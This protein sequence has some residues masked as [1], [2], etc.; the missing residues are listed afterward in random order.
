MSSLF[1]KEK[2]MSFSSWLH[3]LKT[4]WT[5]AFTP[6]ILRKPCRRRVALRLLLEQFEGRILPSTV[7]WIGGSGSWDDASHWFD[8]TTQTNHVPLAGDDVVLNTTGLTGASDAVHSLT[9]TGGTLS[10]SGSITSQQLTISGQNVGDKHLEGLTLV[11][12]GTGSLQGTTLYLGQ[13]AVL[14]NQ[15]SLA[16]A[17]SALFED[18]STAANP[19]IFSNAVGA[20]FDVSSGVDTNLM[21]PIQNSGAIKVEQGELE[22]SNDSPGFSSGAVTG[23]PGTTLRFYRS[24]TPT[25]SISGDNVIFDQASGNNIFF[26]NSTSPFVAD[27]STSSSTT[28]I[29][30]ASPIFTGTNVSVGALRVSNALV[31]FTPQSPAT[32][33]ASS[34]QLEGG[35]LMGDEL[36]AGGYALIKDSGAYAQDSAS[37]LS[38][39]IGGSAA[40]L[41]FDRLCVAG[42]VQLAGVLNLQLGGPVGFVP[43]IG[44]AFTLIDNQGNGPITGTFTGLAEGAIL[45]VPQPNTGASVLFRLTYQGGDG[46]DVVLTRVAATTHLVFTAPPTAKAAGSVIPAIKVSLEDAFGNVVVTD[47]SDVTL[48]IG[49][50]SGTSVTIDANHSYATAIGI[51]TLS[52]TLTVRAVNGV[53][54]FSDLTI[55]TPGDAADVAGY[56]L[57]ASDGNAAAVSSSFDVTS[58]NQPPAPPAAGALDPLFGDHGSVGVFND[59]LLSDDPAAALQTDGKIVVAEPNYNIV[60]PDG[61]PLFGPRESSSGFTVLRYQADGSLDTS[62]GGY[63]WGESR[64]G[65]FQMFADPGNG[66]VNIIEGGGA[67]GPLSVAVQPNDDKILISGIG[68]NYLLATDSVVERLN[69]DGSL[70]TSFGTNGEQ[71]ISFAAPDI[72]VLSDGRIVLGGSNNDGD[73]IVARLCANGSLDSTFG[74]GGQVVIP[75]VNLAGYFPG[76]SLALQSDGKIVLLLGNGAVTRL[77]SDGSVDTSFGSSSKTTTE[78]FSDGTTHTVSGGTTPSFIHNPA[79]EGF[80]A[81]AVYPNTGAKPLTDGKIVLGG[82]EAVRL[83]SDGSL[84]TSYGSGG[85]VS[86]GD[87]FFVMHNLALQADGK[88]LVAGDGGPERCFAVA[89]INSGGSLDTTFGVGAT[90]SI[91]SVSLLDGIMVEP[92]GKVVAIGNGTDNPAMVGLLGG[93]S[94]VT[95]QTA[96]TSQLNQLINM[97]S[98]S[99]NPPEVTFQANG[100][101]DIDTMIAAVNALP[102]ATTSVTVILD[103]NGGTYS[104]NGVAVDP[105]ANVDFTIQNG[106]LDPS[107]PA[108]TVAGGN[109]TVLNCT[110]LTTGNVPTI[111]VSGGSL[112]LRNDSIIQRATAFTGPAIAVT[113]GNLDLGTST[114]PGANVFSVSSGGQ[115]VLNSTPNPINATGNSF[116]VAGTPLPAANLTFTSLAS[117]VTSSTYGQ[118]VIIT[119]TVSTGASGPPTGGTVD[120]V[121]ASS[122]TDLGT[123]PLV[124]GTATTSISTLAAGSH[125]ITARYSGSSTSTFSS[126]SVTLAVNKATPTMSWA[127]PANITYGTALGNAQLNAASSAAVNGNTVSV[128]G[129]FVYGPATGAVLQ[130]GNNQPLTATFTP[131]DTADY[132]S[133]SGSTTIN[134]L[135]APLTVTANNQTRVYGTPNPTFAVSYAGFVTGDTPASLGGTLVFSTPATINSPVGSYVITPSG[136]SSANYAIS[137]V[138]ATLNVTL[139]ANSVYLLNASASGALSMS[140]NAAIHLPGT[141]IVDSTSASAISASGNAQVTATGGV[142][143]AGGVQKSGNASVTKTGTP[144]ATGDPL[145]NLAGPTPPSYT[146][147]PISE[148]IGANT[149]ATINPGLYSQ[150]SVSGNAKLTLNPGVYVIGLGGV[151]VSLNASLTGNGVTYILEGGGFNVSGNASVSGS[152]VL[153][154]NGGSNYPNFGA[155]GQTYGAI[156]LSSNGSFNLSAAST[157]TYAGI[158]IY[159]TRDNNK[160]LS[161]GGN[162]ITG[163][164]GLIYAPSALLT[165]SGNASMQD[166]LIVG[167]LNLNGNITL[168]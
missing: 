22:V 140:S 139:A 162:G 141:L 153:I 55:D 54:T 134:I 92:N 44:E 34:V 107:S 11:N 103:L 39:V 161:L 88:V 1:W 30:H 43:D 26:P 116:E 131:T 68:S 145:A 105:P 152:N 100:Q 158:L 35:T 101:G 110:L 73:L 89:R 29:D 19:G 28:V 143:V 148:S 57:W 151:N 126:G 53:A 91:D 5:R 87:A 32:V 16:G 109:V 150:I 63:T 77:N 58:P 118:T 117:S 52:G 156:S 62:F 6:R 102:P 106:T 108:L 56:T 124:N 166:P 128:P 167:M 33:A 80:L 69:K 8:T 79:Y 133:A 168:T 24:L 48:A 65:S 86:F 15:G 81:L 66:L 115:F 127:A 96:V 51:G 47:N 38:L 42:S 163:L 40:S 114:N 50:N 90:E 4:R 3:T 135:K 10:G 12:Q 59:F 119:A 74:G 72:A 20:T 83:T 18:A 137:Y 2:A 97:A 136:L 155:P 46:N 132:N 14:A 95:T 78:S 121:D 144:G 82:E 113:S 17:D 125:A 164:I 27:Y 146:G 104:T 120:F 70:D 98:P 99:G 13:G 122:N 138:A 67:A 160:G 31:T 142:L 123:F 49:T 76:N 45:N 21:L 64:D 84:D 147:T 36:A 7:S 129:T 112:A 37:T 149:V 159:Q 75:G 157:G 9:W 71:L 41:Q 25:P 94:D 93:P 85:Y 165:L 23:M 60:D 61:N 154:V 111:L 130:A